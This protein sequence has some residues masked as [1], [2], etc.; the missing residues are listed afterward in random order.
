MRLTVRTNHVRLTCS[1]K[2]TRLYRKEDEGSETEDGGENHLVIADLLRS[3][4][5][6]LTLSQQLLQYSSTTTVKC[7][8]IRAFRCFPVLFIGRGVHV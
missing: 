1:E 2:E 7:Q 6:Q 5:N 4:Q 3:N 8:R